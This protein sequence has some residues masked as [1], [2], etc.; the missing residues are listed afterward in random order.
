[1]ER[2]KISVIHQDEVSA[3]LEKLGLGRALTRGELRCANCER[4]IN[5]N[6]F[7]SVGKKAGQLFVLCDSREC[8][9]ER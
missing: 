5:A 6:N 3:L 9:P 2:E 8:S 7:L 4:V 1:M